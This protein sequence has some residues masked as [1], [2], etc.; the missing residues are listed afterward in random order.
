MWRRHSVLVLVITSAVVSWRLRKIL[1]ARI[2]GLGS[3]M[4][5]K[6]DIVI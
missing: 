6:I 3:Y 2:V 5:V 1:D 4:V